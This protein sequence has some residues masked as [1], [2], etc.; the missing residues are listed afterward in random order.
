[1]VYD[2]LITNV[3]IVSSTDEFEGAVGIKDGVITGLHAKG[4]EGELTA[5]TVI[6]GGGKHLLPGGVDA[7][8]HIRYPGSAH[9]ET[10]ATGTRAAAAGGNTT[11]IE[12]PISTPPQY[13]P[14]I[15][16][17]RIEK[18]S[19]QAV[20][21]YAFL[22]AAGGEFPEEIQ[23]I[24]KAGIVGYKTFLHDA[25]EGRA[26]EFVGLTSK[27]NDELLTVLTEI[28]KTGLL[29]AA[30]IED[31]DLVA[32]KIKRLRA[33]GKTYPLAHCESRP[34]VAEV[35]A[36]KRLIT[37]AKEVGA[38]VYLVHVSSP[39]TVEVAIQAREEGMEIYI[40][41]C[42]Q[43]LYLDERYVKKYGAYAKCNPALRDRARVEKMWDYIQ[44]GT[45]DV[46]ASDHAPY[47]VEEKEQSPE[48][49]F[50][51]PSG[52]PGLETRLPLMLKGVKDGKISLNRAVELLCTNPAQIFGLA[53]KGD[54]KIGMDADF[55]LVDLNSEY[56]LDHTKLH[57][58]AKDICKFM[59]GILVAGHIEKTVVRGE[60]VYD[61]EG[62]PVEGGYGQ[63]IEHS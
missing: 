48:D 32:G 13:S 39:E 54:I 41:T 33:E 12:H 55:T 18:V 31:N 57:T 9:R 63:W 37:L 14:E 51:A 42:P 40:E 44:D 10:F 60:I 50:V 29:A 20:V 59:D 56:A 17:D 36:V 52:F 45:I 43:Y 22:G 3:T 30:H 21:D 5:K 46:V 35:L 34:P 62:F 23:R 7:H 26:K 11:I 24:G 38:R 27:D 61:G 49:I 15:L 16:R 28:Q 19:D 53:G 58:M 2:T 25:P 47:T 4:T 6:D 8:V 1:M